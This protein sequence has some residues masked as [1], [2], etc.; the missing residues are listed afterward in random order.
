MRPRRRR[1]ASPTAWARKW[2]PKRS[3]RASISAAM[4]ASL[5]VPWATMT[6][7]LSI[8]QRRA[9]P[10]K[11]TSAWLRKARAVKRLQVG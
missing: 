3:A 5:P 6:L 4:T 10:P 1:S 2:K 9:A 11:W 7:L 8:R